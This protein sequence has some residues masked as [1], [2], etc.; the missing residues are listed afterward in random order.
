MKRYILIAC[1]ALVLPVLKVKADSIRDSLEVYYTWDAVLHG[2]PDSVLHQVEVE[3][4][5]LYDYSFDSDENDSAMRN[6]LK[7]K[8][9]A[10]RLGDER[11]LINSDRLKREY[12][13]ECKRFRHY[14]P[15]Y[16]SAEIKFVQWQSSGVKLGGELLNTMV[17][18]FFGFDPGIGVGDYERGKVAPFYLLDNNDMQV[19]KVDNKLLENLLDAYPD[20]Q[21]R[22]LQMHDSK[23]QYMVNDFFLDYVERLIS[24][25]ERAALMEDENY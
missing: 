5:S 7:D 10:V 16:F 11:W 8:A 21:R 22:Y 23:E 3:V 17:A 13:G 6:L 24:D 18:G 14:V 15:L 1:L 9:L 4:G 20:L 2:T 12:K 25:G 19:K